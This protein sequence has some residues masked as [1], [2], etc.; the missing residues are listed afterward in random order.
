M[1]ERSQLP[2]PDPNIDFAPLGF[3]GTPG[4]HVPEGRSIDIVR[5]AISIWKYL[6]LGLIAGCTVGVLAYLYMGPVY[7]AETQVMVSR[8]ASAGE[9]AARV[10]TDLGGHIKVI[11]SDAVAHIALEK[12]GLQE[13]FGKDKDPLKSV[14]ENLEVK[15]ISGDQNSYESQLSFAYLNSD[16]VVAQKVVTAVVSSYSDWLETRRSTSSQ[17]LYQTFLNSKNE[18][19]QELTALEDEYAQWRESVPFYISS[20]PAVTSQGVP[21]AMASPYQESLKDVGI[22]QRANLNLLRKTNIKIELLKTM[23]ANPEE[24]ENLQTWVLNSIASGASGGAGGEGGTGG[25]LI[26]SPI[27]KSELDQ[28][29]LTARLLEN[30]LLLVLGENHADVRNVRRQI[31]TILDFYQ[32]QGLTPPNLGTSSSTAS[33]SKD[34][35]GA[36]LAQTYLTI[37]ESKV[38]ELEDEKL[39]LASAY[40]EAETTAKSAASFEVVD[41]RYKDDISRKKKELDSVLKQI[42][43]FDLNRQQEGYT[44]SRTNDVRVSRSIK[45]VIKIVGAF[46]VLGL[47]AVFCLA[48]FRE[49]YD[50]TLKTA[51][52]TRD[53]I[54]AAVMGAIPHFKPSHETALERLAQE[55]GLS[56]ALVYFHRPG[57]REAE[58][59]RS[60]RTTL[61][62]STKNSPDKIIQITSAEPGDGKSTTSANLAIA[63]AQ[64]GKKVL[65]ID[66]D[67]RRPTMHTL[68]GLPQDVGLTD[69]LLNEVAWFTAVRPTR[70]NNLSVLTAGLC[71]DNPAELLSRSHLPEMLKAARVAYDFI[72]VDTPPILAISDPAIVAPYMDGLLLV[73]RMGKNRRA[74]VERAREMIDAHGI[75]LYG[76]IVND[77]D[78]T[79]DAY[80]GAY[81]KY[82]EGDKPAQHKIGARETMAGSKL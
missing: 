35:A 29:L 66:A 81:D 3:R 33:S 48:Y 26:S 6:A 55:N 67:L 30:R 53:A 59:Y 14:W 24:R 57:S 7:V 17:D 44:L 70:V 64:S 45:K 16:K 39:S 31:E 5:F 25:G 75:R 78:Y 21:M 9:Q 62:H 47:L 8:K 58:A 37:L 12:H 50:T 15:R 41:Q 65:L 23:M 52:E 74:V 63:I 36:N 4:S 56:P 68:F 43:E 2:A 38:D 60:C 27:G 73:V 69:V 76:V 32:R 18:M 71:P 54:G 72:I 13:I 42:T 61:F 51:E 79:T 10:Y 77:V 1:S 40:K 28:Q 34:K 22:L 20:S 19:D 80:Y 82:F 11:T 49:W 46:G